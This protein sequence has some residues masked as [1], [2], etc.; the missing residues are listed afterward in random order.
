MK[1]YVLQVLTGMEEH[2]AKL[3]ED[4]GN[5]K[6]KKV[7]FLKDKFGGPL[8]PGYVFVE[9]EFDGDTFRPV[10]DTPF[11]IQYLCP[12]SGIRP[13]GSDETESVKNYECTIIEPGSVVDIIDGPLKGLTGSIKKIKL[14]WLKVAIEVF[15]EELFFDVSVK[16]VNLYAQCDSRINN[17]SRLRS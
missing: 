5:P 9:M 15:G 16:H 7:Y 12:V 10:L 4:V 6:I 8:F 17:K 11:V 13:L 14:P 2:V 1:V 3:I